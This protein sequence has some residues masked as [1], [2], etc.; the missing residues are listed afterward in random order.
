VAHNTQG[1][2]D[3]FKPNALKGEWSPFGDGKILVRLIPQDVDAGFHKAHL[4]DKQEFDP[5]RMHAYLLCRASYALLDTENIW[6]P[7]EMVA[8]ALPKERAAGEPAP[9]RRPDG[10]VRLDGLWSDAVKH[11]V[12]AETMEKR[13]LGFHVLDASKALA[14]RIEVKKEELGKA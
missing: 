13:M 6:A 9:D 14:A 12:L 1:P 4:G 8:K 3:L 2:M 11:A 7:G 5:E 10:M